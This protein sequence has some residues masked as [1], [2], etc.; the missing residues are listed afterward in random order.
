MRNSKL[1]TKTLAILVLLFVVSGLA[2]AITSVWW[3]SHALT[4]QYESKGT[5][6]ANSIASSSV[7]VLL[8]RDSSTVQAMIDQYL[9]IQ[10]VAYVFVLD[11]QGDIVAHTFAPSVPECV[12]Q[13]KGDR[14]AT[15][16]QIVDVEDIGECIDVA[17]PLLE[18]EVG[19]VHVGMDRR[20][21]SSAVRTA[22][23]LQS[24]I[25][26]T[27]LLVGLLASYFLVKKI[28][29]PLDQL[30]ACATELAA[31]DST[32]EAALRANGALVPIT[33]RTDEVGHLAKAFW[34]MVLELSGREQRLL[35]A[36][37]TLRASESH[38]RSLIENVTDVIMKLNAEGMANYASPPIE[39]VLGFRSEHFINRNLL[40][41]IHADDNQRVRDTLRQ[42]SQLAGSVSSEEFRLVRR[43]GAYRLVDASFNNLLADPN[44]QS[45]I[46][47]LRD[48]TEH[49]R[50][51]EMWRIAD[52]NQRLLSSISSI[53]IGLDA[54]G[55]ITKWNRAAEDIL[56]VS[57]RVAVGE[58]LDALPI[59]WDQAQ[60]TCCIRDC[61]SLRK[62]TRLEEFSF[63]RRDGQPGLLGIS[64][65]PV[66]GSDGSP[67]GL[68]LLG[69][70]ITERRNLETQLRHSQ[71]LE[72]I[73]QLAAGIAHEINT[74]IQYV[75]DNVNFLKGAF[76]DLHSVICKQ[77]R[78]LAGAKCGRLDDDVITDV[79]Q[80]MA[81]ADLAFLGEEVPRA[82]EQT[83]EGLGRVAKIVRAMKEFSHPGDEGK[84]ASNLN[85][86]IEN[87]ITVA[88]NEWK[89]VAD[90]VTDFDGSL[91]LV[92][93]LVS[94]FNQV[95]LNLIVNAAHAIGDRIKDDPEGKGRITIS[96]RAS[97][98]S[99][100]I[101]VTDT[102]TGMP[103]SVR[104]KEFDP[105]FTT[106]PV[107]KGTGQGL[108]IA[109]A[110][111]VKK[112]GGT[113]SIETE[114]GKGTAFIIRLPLIDP[115]CALKDAP[116]PV[117]DSAST[118]ASV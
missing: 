101:R 24:A 43:D 117:N 59:A 25:M 14:H 4:Q 62:P 88:N 111:I 109:H 73:G 8:Y 98:E 83:L 33:E 91:P 35:H 37:E 31:T 16:I 41:F 30:T 114:L 96:T 58:L 1:L 61:L 57:S 116:A 84:V 70:D 67:Q 7:E 100:E 5:A 77:E 71:K 75:G 9:S 55:R 2:V 93:C 10:G 103:E 51:E 94:E 81:S 115:K 60:L 74:P 17:A 108:T 97:A 56:D 89:Y 6:I 64:I 21:I 69:T 39:H 90:V 80:A 78:L 22:V 92:P 23:L 27:I 11:E 106:K 113:I 95:I 104:L 36:E 53:L 112:H 3:I 18:G 40:E 26:G 49:R 54:T 82:I 107:G 118:C 105:F 52:E 99:V 42:V 29:R 110:V 32:S 12:R 50:A 102:G 47:T 44:V 79:E 63:K 72:S 46:V 65:T 13:L 86:L 45:L 76:A 15:T 20:L 68:L 38:F 19:Y 34:H 48:I 66:F 28:T 87:T 85:N